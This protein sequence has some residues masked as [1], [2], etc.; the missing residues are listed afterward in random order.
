[1]YLPRRDRR[2]RSYQM[3]WLTRAFVLVPA[4]QDLFQYLGL[5]SETSERY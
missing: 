3:L 4:S 2:G 5:R 1:V